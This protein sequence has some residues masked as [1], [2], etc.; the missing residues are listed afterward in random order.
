MDLMKFQQKLKSIPKEIW[1]RFRIKSECSRNSW[2]GRNE[3]W[4]TKFYKNNPPNNGELK[5]I[6][7]K[8]KEKPEI[9]YNRKLFH[10]SD[11][12]FSLKKHPVAY[13]SSDYAIMCCET[14][15]ELRNNFKSSWKE[16][17][18]PYL[19]GISNPDLNAYGYPL[20]FILLEGTS[21][22]DLRR[23][24]ETLKL[25]ETKAGINIRK[26]I[27]SVND[28]NYVYSKELSEQV[29]NNQFDGIIYSSVREPND[30]NLCG[31][32]LIM[33]NENKIDAWSV[34]KVTNPYKASA[35]ISYAKID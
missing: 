13:F 9:P 31:N 23:D 8:V 15:K 30:I 5:Q 26:M 1:E 10:L 32:N 21:I 20:T 29:F 2:N 7:L 24:S 3:W 16:Y 19:D 18:E 17:L 22:L 33:F 12:R 6:P 14:I 27:Y 11:G 35:V 34:E 25:F 4:N 28:N